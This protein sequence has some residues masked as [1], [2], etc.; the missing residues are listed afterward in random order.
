VVGV[1]LAEGRKGGRVENRFIGQEPANIVN[2]VE[3]LA[4]RRVQHKIGHNLQHLLLRCHDLLLPCSL[5]FAKQKI[6][7]TYLLID[8]C[9]RS[10]D[11][12]LA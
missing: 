10:E 1:V 9:R 4:W 5:L 3:E 2:Y 12:S 11:G 7:N 6:K 8:L